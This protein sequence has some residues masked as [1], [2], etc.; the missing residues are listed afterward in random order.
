MHTMLCQ[1]FRNKHFYKSS[2]FLTMVKKVLLRKKNC[3]K[4]PCSLRSEKIIQNQDQADPSD[5]YS[6]LK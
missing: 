4:K 6:V 5:K 3:R 2:T 1:L